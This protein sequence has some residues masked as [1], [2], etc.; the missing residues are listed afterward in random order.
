MNDR[1]RGNCIERVA[2]PP[3]KQPVQFDLLGVGLPFSGDCKMRA[4]TWCLHL[5]CWRDWQAAEKDHKAIRVPPDLRGRRA[6]QV[7][8]DLRARRAIRVRRVRPAPAACESFGWTAPPAP[9]Q[10]SAT[11]MRCWLRPIAGLR[12]PRR[13]SQRKE[14][15]RAVR[16]IRR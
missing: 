9:A 14:V 4:A 12:E 2:K 6:M 11:R 16:P 3:L 15:L 1:L 13:C 7:P 8:P 5:H 10:S